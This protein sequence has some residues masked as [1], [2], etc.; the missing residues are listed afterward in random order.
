[1]GT[2]V[3]N[4]GEAALRL[5]QLWGVGARTPLDEQGLEPNISLARE[6]EAQR[7]VRTKLPHPTTPGCISIQEGLGAWDPCLRSM[8]PVASEPQPAL[9]SPD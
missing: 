1:M 9:H 8:D 5:R 3:G 6:T 4:E 7:D 2:C